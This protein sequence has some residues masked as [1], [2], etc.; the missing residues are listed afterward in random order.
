MSSVHVA[1]GVKGPP[2]ILRVL[3][4][5]QDRRHHPGLDARVETAVAGGPLG[6]PQQPRDVRDRP[7]HEARVR[8]I[9]SVFAP[10]SRSGD[11][12]TV[13]VSSSCATVVVSVSSSAACT[14]AN[15]VPPTASPACREPKKNCRVMTMA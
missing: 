10:K 13:N 4:R 12:S 3:H 15:T 6:L 14:Q 11:T 1:A 9:A 5:A 2:R 8:A 7:H